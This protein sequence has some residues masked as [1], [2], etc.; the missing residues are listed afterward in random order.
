VG[1]YYNP[2]PPHIGAQQPLTPRKLTPPISGP[3]PQNPPLLPQRSPVLTASG[4]AAVVS[5]FDAL[6]A[7]FNSQK[8][9]LV[10]LEPWDPDGSAT[11][12]VYAS[13]HGFITE[14]GDAPA[15]INWPARVKGG[16]HFRRALFQSGKLSGRSLPGAGEI[17]FINEDGALDAWA[18]YG[19]DGRRVRI[20]LGGENFRISDYRLIFDGTAAGFTHDDHG[21][22]LSLRDLQYVLDREI[23][24]RTFAGTGGDEGGSDVAGKKKPLPYGVVRNLSPVYLGIDGVSGLH[25]FAGGDGRAIIGVLRVRDRGLELDYVTGTPAPGQWTVDLTTGVISLAAFDGPLTADVIGRRYRSTTS[26]TS[27]TVAAGSKVF[28]VVSA[29]GLALGQSLRVARTAA[30]ASTFGDGV[31]TAISGTS[32]TVNI[33]TISGAAGPF[34]DWTLSPHGTAAGIARAIAADDLGIA[35]FDTDSLDALDSAQPATVGTWLAE[36]G[37]GLQVLDALM[38]GAGCWYGMT[39]LAAF[40]VGRVPVPSATVVDTYTDRYVLQDTFGRQDTAEPNYRAVVQY[41]RNYDPLSGTDLA[42]LVDDDAR[43]FLVNEWRQSVSEDPS[44]SIAHP[45]SVE[46]RMDGS[47]DAKADADAEAAR[48]MDLF[49][50]KR[51]Y[52]RVDLKTK[53]LAREIGDV[54]SLDHARYGLSGGKPFVIAAIDEDYDRFQVTVDLWG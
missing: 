13:S 39:R 33:T 20:Y 6:L 30:L 12:D 40:Q 54:I 24:T 46:L 7:A 10:H 16:F 28:A 9:L 34:T 2:I 22:V 51:D 50:V 32:V 15:N 17:A 25:K 35:S 8:R 38:D 36:G 29:A 18:G 41:Q 3:A 26:S 37:N 5:L 4:P 53:P 52:L 31:I 49:G 1:L 27:W 14:P 19:W 45:L 43:S 44:V 47:F 23:Q 21:F 11:T 48:Q 42:G